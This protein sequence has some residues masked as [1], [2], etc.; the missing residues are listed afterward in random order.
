MDR[1]AAAPDVLAQLLAGDWR[2]PDGGDPPRFPSLSIVVA[3]SLRDRERDLVAPLHLGDRLAVVSD[4]TTHDVLGGRVERRLASMCS[5]QSVVLDRPHADAATV[6]TLRSKCAPADALVAVGSGTVNDLC[7]AAA[8]ADRK[9]YVVFPTAPS[10][11]GYASANAA[12]TVDGHKQ[13]LPAALPCGIFVD[14][15][16]LAQA[17]AKLIRA[18]VGD[19]ICRSTAQADWMLSRLVRDT[20]YREA[21][22]ALLAPD[23]PRWLDAPEALLGGDLQAIEALARTLLLSGLGMTLCQGSYPASQAEHLI[24]H[25]IDMFAPGDRGEVLHGEQVAVATLTMARIQQALLDGPV[26]QAK[27]TRMTRETLRTRFGAAIGASCW[28]HFQSKHLDASSAAQTTARIA[29]C[30]NALRKALHPVLV[31]SERIAEILRRIG[32]PTEPQGIGVS[33]AFYAA[34]VRNAR[35]LRDRYTFLD[36]ADDAGRL[37]ALAAA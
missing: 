30:W 5:I 3:A 15:S 8:A 33:V 10:M 9:R 36:L 6:A 12:I 23:E 11:N 2:D 4:R 20:P 19:S 26:P 29:D 35:Y 18:G 32:A 14:L 34:A 1:P 13:S 31:P 21:P 7:K 16:V 27:P 24:S 17:P 37:D 22:F 28:S 25:Y